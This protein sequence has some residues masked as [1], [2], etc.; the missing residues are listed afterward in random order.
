[1]KIFRSDVKQSQRLAQITRLQPYSAPWSVEGF[2]GDLTDPAAWVWCCEEDGKTVGFISLRVAAGWA[3]ILNMAV[4]PAYCRR[5]IGKKL[6]SHALQEAKNSGAEEVTLEVN[7]HNT[8]AVALYRQAGLE[9]KG[10][11]KKF[12]NNTDDALI[13]GKKL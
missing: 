11:R 3:E 8:A 1:M 13:M 7:V 9:E 6:L 2:A 5:G 10:I 12:Y 4:D